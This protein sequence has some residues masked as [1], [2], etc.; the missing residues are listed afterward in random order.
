MVP[1]LSGVLS[2][3]DRSDNRP[4]EAALAID[5]QSRHAKGLQS[6]D[7]ILVL[8][9]DTVFYPWLGCRLGTPGWIETRLTQSALDY[10]RVS[11]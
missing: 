3:R 5:R 1:Q 10:R 6:L 4:E 7:A 9:E 11:K 2:G 8:R